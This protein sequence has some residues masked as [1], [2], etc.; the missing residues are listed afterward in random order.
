[1]TDSTNKDKLEALIDEAKEMDEENYT[2]ESFEAL[3]KALDE[4]LE[5]YNNPNA[6]QVEID[7]ATSM[8]QK[9][10]DA[11]ELVKSDLPDTGQSSTTIYLIGSTLLI[12]AGLYL[13][14]KKK[15]EH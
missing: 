14:F 1:M 13:M 7:A 15:E 4:A 2:K 10:L 3:Q 11:L 12:S 9:A 6:T 8:L 5:V